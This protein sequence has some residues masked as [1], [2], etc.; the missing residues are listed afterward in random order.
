MKAPAAFRA[1]LAEVLSSG[2]AAPLTPRERAYFRA[3]PVAYAHERL[4]VDLMPHQ[5]A[6][7][8][9]VAG[10]WHRITP[11]MAEIGKMNNPGKRKI[12]VRSSV[13]TGKSTMLVTIALWYYECC[14]DETHG[15]KFL[16]TAAKGDQIRTVI[17][18]ELRRI[19]RLAPHPPEGKQ[20]RDPSKGF[21]SADESCVILGFTGRTAE[22][23]AGQ[24]GRQS[25]AVDEASSLEKEKADAIVGNLSGGGEDASF[26]LWL[27]NPVR[28]S[29]PLYDAFHSK[30]EHYTTFHFDGVPISE[31]NERQAEPTKYIIT[32]QAIRESAAEN[33]ERDPFHVVRMR[34]DFVEGEVGKVVPMVVIAAAQERWRELWI[35]QEGRPLAGHALEARR[36]LV[37]R[38]TKLGKLRIGFD[39]AGDKHGRDASGF[40][41]VRGVVLLEC[42][43]RHGHSKEQ[44]L[45]ELW[46]LM[47]KYRSEDEIPE[48]GVDVEGEI[49][50]EYRIAIAA[51]AEAR[52]IQ[53]PSE[54]FRFHA[55]RSSSTNVREP[56]FYERVRAELWKVLA[57]WMADAAIPPDGKLETELY[58]PVWI[59]R[60][61]K[62]PISSSYTDV[63]SKEGFREAIHR[64]P[65]LADAVALALYGGAPAAEEMVRQQVGEVGREPEDVVDAN[66]ALYEGDASLPSWARD[67]AS[68]DDPFSWAR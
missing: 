21:K 22:A 11:E 15:A 24:S 7:A 44:N 4:G 25:V 33:G 16:L 62:G 45:A 57:L 65:D 41:V 61:R 38:T 36:A 66:A 8:Y 23:M 67:D 12:A 63:T 35:D 40:A 43:V 14:R 64:S 49:G 37:C 68:D 53:R 39:P 2:L 3:E 31:W 20:A 54:A 60:L 58:C 47:A 27:A 30:K 55:I 50:N 26:Q 32:S 19:L 9:A 29:G 52:R 56:R 13:K 51:E 42:F 17:W 34:G 18:A 59:Q 5:Q 48:L 28:S 6:V 1:A 46:Q 10:Q